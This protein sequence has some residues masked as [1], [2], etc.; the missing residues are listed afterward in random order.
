MNEEIAGGPFGL[1]TATATPGGG[2]DVTGPASSTSNNISVFGDSSGKVIADGGVTIAQL[3]A[4]ADFATLT[5]GASGADY[6]TIQSALDNIGANGGTIWLLDPSYSI[7]SGLLVKSSR[8]EIIGKGNGT[9]I[10]CDGAVVTTLFK[11]NA[12]T[13]QGFALRNV[14][15]EQT[16]ATVQGIA[17]DA[18]NMSLCIYDNVRILNFG[19]AI[20]GDD[21]NNN[22][23]YNIFRDI[24]IF[25]CNNGL[26]FTS[27]NPFNDNWFYDIRTALR[28]GGGGTGLK[29]NN[30]QGNAFYNLNVE[31]AVG[32]GITGIAL[33][34]AN[35]LDTQFFNLYAENN[36]TNVSIG[37]GVVRTTFVGGTNTLATTTNLSDLG[38]QTT[39]INHRLGSVL[40]NLLSPAEFK[41]G[42]N[43][44]SITGSFYNNTSFAH[45]GSTLVKMEL[46][47]ATDSSAVLT[48]ANAGSGNYITAGSVFT[49]SS[50]GLVTVSNASLNQIALAGGASNEASIAVT[51]SNTSL[52][53]KGN[54]TASSG[55]NGDVILESTATRTTG[56]VLKVRNN[57]SDRL[58]VN[59]Y[60]GVNMMM[61]AVS[62]GSRYSLFI[63]NAN[64]TSQATTVEVN[65]IAYDTYTRTWATG[66]ITTQREVYFPAVTYAFA[67][68]SVITNAAT[69][70][71]GGAPIAGTNATLTNSYNLWLQSGTMRSEGKISFDSTI[72]AGGTTG[73]QTINKPTGSVNFAAAASSLVVTNSLVT[74]N[75]FIIPIVMTNDTTMKSCQVVPTA[76]SFTLYPNA[77][78]TAET[79]V[80]FIVVN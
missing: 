56:Q 41:D 11:A 18:S 22:T 14:L 66:A 57:G 44:S 39:F 61:A 53:L 48:L 74:A 46:L 64:H 52:I 70:A 78:P 26:D 67:G 29:M 68:A 71:I 20:K 49:V 35:V 43:S 25:E 24:K 55:N 31:P 9:R 63:D 27:T 38:T 4:G 7:T 73:A 12:A 60:G 42:G 21:T 69:L 13:Y 34:T 30:A 28:A 51:A 6:T 72:T 79:K 76:G 19:T 17:I 58:D 62:G 65:N 40:K 15:L 45:T 80:A 2:G 33:T 16:N 8:V 77:T 36:A 23:F 1:K 5:V 75:S 32:A 37:S 54:R 3:Q 47:N 50:S 59:F 10:F